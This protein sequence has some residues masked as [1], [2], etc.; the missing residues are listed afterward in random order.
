VNTARYRVNNYELPH[1]WIDSEWV[2]YCNES[3]NQ[4]CRETLALIDSKTASVCEIS[5]VEDTIDYSLAAS[6]IYINSAK[7]VTEET[8]ILDVKPSTAW[9][10]GDTIT[11]ASST[12]TC[13]IVS[14]IS[15]YSYV[16]ENRSGTFT[17]GEVLSNGTYSADQGS[18]YPVFDVYKSIELKKSTRG[19][20]DNM[21]SG[22]RAT[23]QGQPYKYLLDFNTGYI[24]L[25]PKPDAVYIIKLNV[26][27]YPITAMST[28]NMSAQTPELDAKYHDAIVNGMCAQACLKRGEL[29]FDPKQAAT[30]A[31]LFA[32]AIARA[33]VK[34]MM[35]NERE[36]IFSPHGGFI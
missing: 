3:L 33:K 23:T 24:S 5:T 30:F 36:N 7:L 26:S 20:M 4:F 28:T 21:F 25:Y 9:A 29:T 32:N 11:G 15:D 22:W 2:H 8:M 35:H 16:V 17:L 1:S 13:T 14:K 10:A 18:S 31:G 12:K 19:E 27:R 6:I 34:N